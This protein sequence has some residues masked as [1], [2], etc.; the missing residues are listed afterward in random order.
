MDE[1]CRRSCSDP[2]WFLKSWSSL[3]NATGNQIRYRACNYRGCSRTF[4]CRE[5]SDSEVNTFS[6]NTL[7]HVAQ[8]DLRELVCLIFSKSITAH[9]NF[10]YCCVT[11]AIPSF[12]VAHKS[13]DET[14][15]RSRCCGMLFRILVLRPLSSDEK[16]PSNLA[17][18]KSLR[19]TIKLQIHITRNT[20][21][22]FAA[23]RVFMRREKKISMHSMYRLQASRTCAIPTF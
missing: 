7:A 1:L 20:L 17:R 12:S 5:S 6:K 21:H 14:D 9:I 8:T 16:L 13:H 23:R 2:T 11:I 18:R 19:F 10:K 22:A 4:R 15:R 3:L